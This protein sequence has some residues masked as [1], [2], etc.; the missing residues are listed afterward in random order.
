VREG[1]LPGAILHRKLKIL[2]AFLLLV[3]L[4]LPMSTCTRYVGSEGKRI[5]TYNYAIESFEPEDPHWW[6]DLLAFVW[7][8][9]AVALLEWRK[10]GLLA[11]GIR[12]LEPL[13]LAVSFWLLGFVSGFLASGR[14]FGAYMAFLAVSIY[15]LGTAWVDIALYREWRQE[16]RT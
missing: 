2:G 7:P 5:T 16:S 6:V 12:I 8:V 3:S 10:R 4:V 14:A 13:M 15:G 11:L 1:N 9:L